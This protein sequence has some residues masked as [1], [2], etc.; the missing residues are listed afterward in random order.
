MWFAF[1]TQAQRE[2]TAHDALTTA[3]ITSLFPHEVREV[4][5]FRHRH[6]PAKTK[7][8]RRPLLVG[9]A[10]CRYNGGEPLDYWFSRIFGLVMY[11]GPQRGHVQI[12]RSVVGINGQPMPIPQ[13]AVE[14]LTALCGIKQEL[15]QTKPIKAGEPAKLK[16]GPFAGHTVKVETVRGEQARVLLGILGSTREITVRVDAM[17]A[18]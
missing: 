2:A 14:H 4:R 12:V 16:L 17:E 1:R 11:G 9:Y 8:V 6:K 18:A 13:H 15:P 7:T 5:P 3:G 10:L